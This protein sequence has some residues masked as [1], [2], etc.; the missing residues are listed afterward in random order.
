MR[1]GI[2]GTQNN[3]KTSLVNAIKAYWPNYEVIDASYKKIVAESNMP[4]NQDGEVETQRIIRDS[5]CEDVIK[6]ASSK[7][8]VCDRTILDNIVYT[9]WL[10]GK[11]KITDDEFISSS[12]NICRETVKM[13]DLILWLPLNEDIPLNENKVNRDN[14]KVYREEI[15]SIFEAVYQG[16][17]EQDGILF[18]IKDQPPMIPL[19]GDL[20]EKIA[21]LKEYINE[22]GDPLET[23]QS[24]FQGLEEMYDKA[25]LVQQLSQ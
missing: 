18:D 17:L 5:L 19:T 2:C 11:D 22:Q 7:Y 3:G 23:E 20:D 25:Q 14:D 21:M 4:I 24:V 16:Y 15:N 1:I 6:N 12:I 9:L 10:G 8:T 13:Y